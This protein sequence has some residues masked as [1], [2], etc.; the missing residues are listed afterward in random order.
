MFSSVLHWQFFNP[1]LLSGTIQEKQPEQKIP[2]VTAADNPLD[3]IFTQP[4]K[5][6]LPLFPVTLMRT[7]DQTIVEKRR[8]QSEISYYDH[9]DLFRNHPIT[10]Y[11]IS[12]SAQTSDG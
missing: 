3:Y 11:K 4:E 8:S 12:L 9:N 5:I 7:T 10:T 2:F 1:I 6:S